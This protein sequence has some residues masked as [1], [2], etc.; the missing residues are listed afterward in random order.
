MSTPRTG[1]L[2]RVCPPPEPPDE[3]A[4]IYR[5]HVDYVWRVIARLGVAPEAVA[6][7]VQEVFLVVHR[8]LADF[9][10]RATM[11]AWL[12]GICRGTARNHHRSAARRQRRLQL[13]PPAPQSASS[14]EIEALELGR[15][16]ADVLDTLDEDQRLALVLTDIEGLSPAEVASAL[17]ISR[18]TVYSR[19]RLARERL[20]REL[21]LVAPTRKGAP[22]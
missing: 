17:G 14:P 12:A 8:R 13:L 15:M 16:V 11:R 1:P 9:D 18:N 20:R 7:I 6:D 2:L 5:T 3:F 21:E 22:R 19:L 4:T 10:G